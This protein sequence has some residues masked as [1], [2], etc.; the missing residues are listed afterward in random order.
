MLC[1]A[2]TAT[3]RRNGLGGC[4]GRAAAE[5][6]CGGGSAGGGS[7]GLRGAGFADVVAGTAGTTGKDGMGT[8]AANPRAG[9]EMAGGGMWAR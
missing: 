5:T 3:L 2:A 1:G 9:E 4:S 8:G 6:T 7:W